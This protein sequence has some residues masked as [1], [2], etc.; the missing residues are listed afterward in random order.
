VNASVKGEKMNKRKLFLSLCLLGILIASPLATGLIT[1]KPTYE[2][3]ISMR[4][5]SNTHEGITSNTH[6]EHK[7]HRAQSKKH[8]KSI[9]CFL[10]KHPMLPYITLGIVALIVIIVGVYLWKKR[11]SEKVTVE[12]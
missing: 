12:E 10:E 8:P 6:T 3:T 1:T 5:H 11:G 2:N 7:P 9:G 4:K